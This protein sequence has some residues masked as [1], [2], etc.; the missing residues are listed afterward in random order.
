MT[1]RKRV[2]FKATKMM[3]KKVDVS[4]RTRQGK[5]VTFRATKT[6]PKKVEVDFYAK[7]RK[8]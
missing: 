5:K 6:V 8:R 3:P 1:R 2:T 7:R 4:F